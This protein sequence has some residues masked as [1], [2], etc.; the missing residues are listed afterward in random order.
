MATSKK[1]K[2]QPEPLSEPEPTNWYTQVLRDVKNASIQPPATKAE[3]VAYYQAKYAGR[4]AAGWKQHL[5]HDLLPFTPQTGKNPAKNLAK[6]FDPQRLHN[7]EPRNAYQY[8]TLGATIGV[9]PPE[10]GYHIHYDGWILFSNVC[11]YRTF[12]VYIVGEWSKQVAADP[13][14]VFPAMF[15]LYMEEDDQD[16]DI[17]EQSPSVGFCE[18]G[19]KSDNGKE[20]KNPVIDV[21]A[22][23]QEVSSGHNGQRRRFSFFA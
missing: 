13:T 21:S 9:K 15:L 4:G 22:N 16:R 17:D 6:R 11:S 2:G 5:I 20:V 19:D 10:N 12:D 7:P 3:V 18:H 14:L 23:Q 1:K 8:R